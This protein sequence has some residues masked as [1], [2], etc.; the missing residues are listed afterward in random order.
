MT[1]T[2]GR[3]A[4]R[5]CEATLLCLCLASI[6]S[7]AP[8]FNT[9]PLSA[10]SHVCGDPVTSLATLNAAIAEFIST[11][12]C[13]VI[14]IG[15]SFDIEGAITPIAA[16]ISAPFGVPKNLTIMG[17]NYVLSGE[18][19]P[20]GFVIVLDE[21]TESR[22]VTIDGLGLSNFAGTGALTVLHGALSVRRSRFVDNE[23]RLP[24]IKGDIG[25][26]EAQGSAGAINAYG[27]LMIMESEFIGNSGDLGGAVHSAADTEVIVSGTTFADNDAATAGGA[28]YVAGSLSMRNST[29]TD[30][31]ATSAGG[32]NVAG[33]INLDFCTIVDNMSTFTNGALTAGGAVTVTNSILYGNFSNTVGESPT[34]V[35]IVSSGEIDVSS[36]LLTSANSVMLPEPASLM[37]N[38]TVYGDPKLAALDDNG[39]FSLP[40]GSMIMTMMPRSGSPVIDMITP[41]GIGTAREET[42]QRGSGFPRF[43]GDLAELG[44]IEYRRTSRP[45]TRNPPVTD[46]ATLPDTH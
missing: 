19:K 6:N 17:N 5:R 33:N 22:T 2:Q 35:D 27:A 28:M 30:N 36:S 3:T 44:A 29:V 41:A 45:S 9:P 32:L 8:L 4:H 20:A 39:G 12:P 21:G 38:S 10:D 7:L 25:S 23:F 26:S 14:E 31:V 11:D 37:A 15:E 42:D 24:V 46:E 16:D 13:T 40:G 1:R 34:V 43:A 18:G